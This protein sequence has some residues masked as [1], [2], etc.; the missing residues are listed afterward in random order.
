VCSHTETQSRE[1]CRDRFVRSEAAS[2]STVQYNTISSPCW[3]GK[4]GKLDSE[5]CPVHLTGDEEDLAG[6]GHLCVLSGVNRVFAG[7]A[8]C[9][10][11]RSDRPAGYA[12][13]L[14]I[15]G[16]GARVVLFFQQDSVVSRAKAVVVRR[17][18]LSCFGARAR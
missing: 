2:R 3:T 4:L 9:L 6:T 16:L 10:L 5:S 13:L 7:A 17:L 8:L 12:R 11:C 18:S 14:A 15:A 1:C